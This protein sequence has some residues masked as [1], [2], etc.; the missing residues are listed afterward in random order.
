MLKLEIFGN[1]KGTMGTEG[2]GQMN[3][4]GFLCLPPISLFPHKQTHKAT[5]ISPDHHTKNQV[6]NFAIDRK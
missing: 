5:W 6:D 1:W 2:L 4:N 3:E